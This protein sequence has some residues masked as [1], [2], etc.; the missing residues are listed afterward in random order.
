MK[1]DLMK[2]GMFEITLHIISMLH[3][4]T[5]SMSLIILIYVTIHGSSYDTCHKGHFDPVLI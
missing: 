5:R 4:H 2:I 1:L 3:I